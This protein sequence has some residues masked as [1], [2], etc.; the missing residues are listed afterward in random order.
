M[1]LLVDPRSIN[2]TKSSLLDCYDIGTN[3]FFSLLVQIILQ[4][5]H[6]NGINKLNSFFQT[7][8]QFFHRKI[9]NQ[10]DLDIDINWLKVT[11]FNARS[12]SFH[13]HEKP[14]GLVLVIFSIKIDMKKL[15]NDL[16][17]VPYF[18]FSFTFSSK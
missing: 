16:K 12:I 8:R 11:L 2:A 5:L 17:I 7:N 9:S 6:F 10:T 14:D 3:L 1:S 4:F 15:L 18:N 13:Y